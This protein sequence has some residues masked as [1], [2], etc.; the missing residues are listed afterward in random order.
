MD[1]EPPR[2]RGVWQALPW[3]LRYGAAAGGCAL[4]I[5]AVVYLALRLAVLLAPLT[6]AVIVALLLT[7]LLQPVTDRIAKVGVPRG[8]AALA[9]VVGL[10]AALVLP[11]VLMW[12]V[13]AEQAAKI[14]EQLGRGLER[15]RGWIV[16]TFGISD[17]Q[18]G[19][20]VDRVIEQLRSA[21]PGPAASAISV[22]EVLG[23]AL[24]ALVLLF[25]L[26]KDGPAMAR[27]AFRLLPARS[28]ER[29]AEAAGNGWQAVSRYT[30]GTMAVAAIDAVGIGLALVVIG[31]PLALPLALLTFVGAFVP[32]LGAT[33]A[34]LLA[35]VV[36]LAANGPVDALLVLAAVIAVQQ[37][38]GNV[39]QPLIMGQALRLHPVIVLVAVT[40]GALTAGVAGALV[41]VPLTAVVYQFARTLATHRPPG[42]EASGEPPG[43]VSAPA[44][45]T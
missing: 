34:G 42:R 43:P 7:A 28:S 13:V 36:A 33:V 1:T 23:A 35:T 26:L 32:I 24:L 39:L 40:A 11:V 41:A 45:A 12:Q 44:G 4:I 19:A 30:R 6:M 38:E 31:V 2:Y 22:V 27:W 10:L 21:A 37:L 25:F 18:L 16:N 14:P 15:L 5:A 8:L 29:W 3:S 17:E 20:A 9:G